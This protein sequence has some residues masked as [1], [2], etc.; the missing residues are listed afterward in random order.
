MRAFVLYFVFIFVPVLFIY[1]FI[2]VFVLLF[3]F[4]FG[5]LFCFAL[6]AYL[7]VFTRFF[8]NRTNFLLNTLN[9]KSSTLWAFV[10]RSLPTFFSERNL[11]GPLRTK[12]KILN[13]VLNLYINVGLFGIWSK[14]GGPVNRKFGREVAKGM[15]DYGIFK[16]LLWKMSNSDIPTNLMNLFTS[17]I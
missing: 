16:F 10:S 13:I 9:V 11:Q 6:V 5:I 4:C 12:S 7:F 3:L 2:F 17:V 15:E 1:S 14:P 8:D